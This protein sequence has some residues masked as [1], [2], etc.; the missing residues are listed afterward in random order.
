MTRQDGEYW[1]EGRPLE[2]DPSSAVEAR[3]RFR[4]PL[5]WFATVVAS[6]FTGT[7][8]EAAGS[9]LGDGRFDL[10]TV[11]HNAFWGWITLMIA[12]VILVCWR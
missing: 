2:D 3:R 8:W 1:L 7:I 9:A 12:A 10:D 5:W 4:S 11:L 6:L